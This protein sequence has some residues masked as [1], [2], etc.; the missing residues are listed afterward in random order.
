MHTRERLNKLLKKGFLAF[1]LSVYLRADDLVTYTITKEED[2]G[3]QRFLAKKCLRGY[4]Q[5]LKP[6]NNL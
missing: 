6:Y 5:K 4:K 2:L 1:F 3:Y